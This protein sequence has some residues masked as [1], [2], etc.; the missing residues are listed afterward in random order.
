[1]ESPLT[2]QPRPEAF[3]QKVV[4]LYE[5][6]FKDD[7]EE[8]LA[9]T[10]G[11]WQEFFLLRP[12]RTSLRRILDELGPEELL[13]RE[14]ETRELFARAIAAMKK[15]SKGVA[16]I[17]ALEVGLVPLFA[18]RI[19]AAISPGFCMWF[20]TQ[21]LMEVRLRFCAARLCAPSL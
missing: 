7:D 12:D 9:Q 6:L 5:T 21:S 17:H 20:A 1:M 10:E 4:R 13:E 2:Q 19:Q 3:Q 16:D 14:D 11:F 18:S 15:G 8:G